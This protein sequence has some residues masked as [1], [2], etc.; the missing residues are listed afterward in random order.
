MSIK[1]RIP[2]PMQ[3]LTGGSEIVE[4]EGDKIASLI[5]D[6]NNKFPGIKDRVYDDS[7]KVRRFINIYINEEDIN[8][9]CDE[10]GDFYKN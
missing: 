5:E 7:G 8:S 10:I 3:K 2:Q 9:I 4:G 1:V 6:L